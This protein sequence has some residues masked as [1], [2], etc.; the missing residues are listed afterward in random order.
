MSNHGASDWQVIVGGV[1]IKTPGGHAMCVPSQA[2]ATCIIG[3]WEAYNKTPQAKSPKP[4]TAMPQKVMPMYCAVATT[5]DRVRPGRRAILQ[6]LKNYAA[7]E[8]F[9]HR[10]DTPAELAKKQ[11]AVWQPWLDWLEARYRVRLLVYSG[12]MPK[13]Q[14]EASLTRLSEVMA[15]LGDFHLCGVQQL[16][17]LG[18]SLVAALAV[19]DGHKTAEEAFAASFLDELWQAQRWGSDATAETRRQHIKQSMVEAG[20]FL[21]LLDRA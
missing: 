5:L 4:Q 18:G 6:G 3:E 8:L 10:S 2:L 12:L 14:P 17:S 11:Q 16:A 19:M 1:A 20:E 9:C 21:S 13:P 15:G 7:H